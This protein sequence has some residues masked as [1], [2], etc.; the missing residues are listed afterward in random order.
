MLFKPVGDE[1]V[2]AVGMSSG[3]SPLRLP[4]VRANEKLAVS[5]E[6]RGRLPLVREAHEDDDVTHL[7]KIWQS[8]VDNVGHRAYQPLLSC[9]QLPRLRNCNL[10]Q[11]ERFTCL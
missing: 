2:S 3:E 6:E 11:E 5:G 4:L 7:R 8:L 9:N 1:L 10:S